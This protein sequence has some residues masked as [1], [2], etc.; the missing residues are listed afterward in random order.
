M[1][2]RSKLLLALVVLGVSA[3]IG[4]AYAGMI[5]SIVSPDQLP[6]QPVVGVGAI[7]GVVVIGL[8]SSA[9]LDRRAWTEMGSSAGLT[10]GGGTRF[11]GGPPEKSDKP[12]L[13]GTVGGRPVRARTY[14]TGGSRN[15]SSKTY[16][17][18]E[19]ELDTPVD[20]HASFGFEGVEEV[21]DDPGIDAAKT[22][23]VDGVGVRGEI[24]EDDAR[25][26]LTREVREAVSA[27]EGEVAVGDVTEN[28]IDDVL[29]ELDD[30]GGG[31]ARTF[32]KGM[33]NA[34]SD[35]NDGPSRMVQHRDRGLLTN[36]ETLR[37]RIDAVTALADAVD[38]T[39]VSAG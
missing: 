24:S 31:M 13:T 39:S 38:R 29:D 1:I 12:T 37:R 17:V 5:E 32:A 3:I 21:P 7:L 35:G 11:A 23:T 16:T 14:S 36:E 22:R 10:A 9:Y 33:L 8:L 34:G 19:A 28:V 15:E 25:A 4:L 6:G 30:G 18:V 26:V 2:R 20:W 27:V